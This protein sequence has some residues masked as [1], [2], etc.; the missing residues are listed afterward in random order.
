MTRS[1]PAFLLL[2]VLLNSCIAG[3]TLN[4]GQYLPRDL[5]DCFHM[6]DSVLPVDKRAQI[7]AN[8]EAQFAEKNYLGLGK[9]IVSNWW[10]WEESQ[11]YRTFYGLGV[12][13]TDDMMHVILTSYHRY[14]SKSAL[15][16]P[17]QIDRARSYRR[18]IQLR[19]LFD[20]DSVQLTHWTRDSLR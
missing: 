6:L 8:T 1:I 12:M 14:L 16:I 3:R 17:E 10:L 13:E 19:E 5:N 9:W 18:N 15:A 11:L 2:A 7:T 20:L 4:F